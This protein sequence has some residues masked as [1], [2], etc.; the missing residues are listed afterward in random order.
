V[1]KVFPHDTT[2]YTEGLLYQDGV[3]YESGG[4]YLEQKAT[5]QS[6][7]D[8]IADLQTG[9]VNLKPAKPSV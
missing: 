4:G 5:G 3:M 6:K 7:A 8:A 1:E 2:T 9:R